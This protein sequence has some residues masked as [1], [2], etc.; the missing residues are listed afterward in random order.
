MTIVPKGLQL[1]KLLWPACDRFPTRRTNRD[2][3]HTPTLPPE[4]EAGSTVTI[5]GHVLA[6]FNVASHFPV[7]LPTN[8][9]ELASP[10]TQDLA[11]N[12]QAFG[13]GSWRGHCLPSGVV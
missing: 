4:L 2:V 12:V 6:G 8:Q 5:G 3:G 9:S 1:A 7:A 10:T 11:E 13:I